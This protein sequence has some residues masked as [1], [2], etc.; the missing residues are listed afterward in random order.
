[1]TETIEAARQRR[2][3]LKSGLRGCHVASCEHETGGG[4]RSKHHGDKHLG[5]SEPLVH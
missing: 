4:E 1:M 2:R 3:M 5:Q